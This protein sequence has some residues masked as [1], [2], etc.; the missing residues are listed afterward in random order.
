M[1]K[2]FAIVS[3]VAALAALAGCGGGGGASEP[4]NS[5]DFQ[6][7]IIG[8]C[9]DGT[10]AWCAGGCEGHGDIIRKYP[11]SYKACYGHN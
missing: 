4:F 7:Y 8:E 5:H 11:A 9:T 10:A 3:T 1:K 2:L 6:N